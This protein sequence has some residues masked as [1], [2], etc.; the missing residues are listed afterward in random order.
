MERALNRPGR[1]VT[2]RVCHT[3]SSSCDALVSCSCP[4][5]S[6]TPL[7]AMLHQPAHATVNHS[8]HAVDG[9]GKV[10]FNDFERLVKERLARRHVPPPGQA[11]QQHSAR[12]P[13][14]DQKNPA[15]DNY[16]LFGVQESRSLLGKRKAA[17]VHTD[18]HDHEHAA[19]NAA[20]DA[21]TDYQTC[22]DLW[23]ALSSALAS[24]RDATCSAYVNF[25]GSYALVADPKTPPRRRVELVSKDLRRFAK[26][27]HR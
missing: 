19:L 18:D 6:A 21:C 4:R 10:Y 7:S 15:S 26:L 2:R 23:D 8:A 11:A 24:S 17:D 13:L 22:E 16:A 12:P 27:P 20:D 5:Y 3:A 25:R 14:A 9:A 1:Y